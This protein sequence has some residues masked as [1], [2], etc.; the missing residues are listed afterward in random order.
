ML[1]LIRLTLRSDVSTDISDEHIFYTRQLEF[2]FDS[3]DKP[4][5]AKG[6]WA[7]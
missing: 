3:M 2:E 1:Y 5:N 6:S 4:T 7:W